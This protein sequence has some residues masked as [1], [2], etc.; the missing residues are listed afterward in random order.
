MWG[1]YVP[2]L[3]SC[4]AGQFDINGL[5]S[6]EARAG[7]GPLDAD[8]VVKWGVIGVATPDV[9]L[10]FLSRTLDVRLDYAPRIFWREPNDLGSV[11]PLILHNASLSAAGQPSRRVRLTG[12]ANASAGEADYTALNQILGPMQ[13]ALPHLVEFLSI[14]A[15]VTGA[16]DITRLTKL[17]MSVSF[18]HRRPLG[19]TADVPVVD[20]TLPPFPRQT[21][22]M[23][24]PGVTT[25]LSRV[26]DMTI[27]AISTYGTYSG[28]YDIFTIVPQVGWRLHLS[29]KYDLRVGAG[30]AYAHVVPALDVLVPLAPVG[31]LGLDMR[32]S[33]NGAEST[34]A[35]LTARLDYMVDPVLGSVGPRAL[36]SAGLWSVLNP[37]WQVGAEAGYSTVFVGTDIQPGAVVGD[38]TSV[39]VSI[40]IR[41]RA[42]DYALMEFGFRYADRA[43]SVEISAFGF[44]Q[45]QLWLYYSLTAFTRRSTT[46]TVQ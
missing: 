34:R 45:R 36:L 28:G 44:H 21:S 5:L 26:T 20:P 9:Q 37:N 6:L 24:A 19:A 11:R 10:S 18:T 13:A 43:P 38:Q 16:V 7:Q 29:P 31:E 42:G 22:V 25:S 17:T 23:V 27:G 4:L 3:L 33:K 12:L 14:N 39:N 2:V 32:L 8:G 41:H 40:P 1:L 46:R 30:I 35:S 15:L